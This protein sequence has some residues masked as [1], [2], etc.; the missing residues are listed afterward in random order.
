MGDLKQDSRVGELTTP[1]GKDVLVLVRF[2]GSE[3]LSELFEYRFECLSED[4]DLD[5]DRAI[6]QQCT[7]KLKMYDKEREYNGILV[8]AQWVGIRDAYYLYRLV[9][10]PWLWLLSRTTD[11]RIWLDKKA[12]DIIK[13]V[14]NDRGFT[15]YESKLTE[16]GSCPK[17]EYCVQ[18][19]ETDLNFVSRLMEQH[20]I[21][22]FFK[23]EGGKH[24]LVLADSKSS[25]SPLP[26]LSSIPFVHLAGAD[27]RKEQ[28]IYEWTSERR[29]RTGKFELNDYNYE[30][31]SAQMLSDAKASERYQHSDM[32]F[33]DYPGKYKEKS[34][35]ERYA[36]IQM[37]SEQALDHRRHGNGDAMGI[38]P[39]G[40]TTLKEH[41]QS[42][43]NIEYLV[44]RANHS[45]VAE[46]YRS[47]S[48]GTGSEQIYYGA[49]EFLPSDRPFRAPI[50]TLK[51]LIHGIQTAKVVTKDDNSNEEIDAESIS[52]IYVR[53]HWDRKKKRSCK[54]RVAQVWSGKRWG[55]QFI[56]RVG[57]E[58]VIEFLEGDPDRPLVIGTVYNDD[59]KLPYDIPGN[60]T[61]SGIKSDSTKGGGGYNEW[62]FEDKKG[63]EKIDLHAEKDYQLVIRH[64]ETRT[65]GETF[66]SGT[67][68]EAT[69]KNGD[70]KLDVQNGS[71]HVTISNDQTVD[72]EQ[73]ITVTANISI[74]LKV[75]ASKI[76]LE[77]SGI[78]IEAPT[79]NINSLGAMVINGTPV[80]VN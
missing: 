32:E 59:H 40:L 13:E 9:L 74:E 5:F 70:D 12:P 4:A 39:G 37:Q 42:S 11:C 14:F 79:I 51:P 75:G 24:T 16:E 77:Q 3:G 21:Y 64:A 46:A 80:S 66:G 54:L 35:G 19:R 7:L 47:G 68:R 26:G 23:H 63:S 33:Y 62:N 17:L 31:S 48:Y 2:D 36:K 27:R 69:L 53:F 72:V 1:L 67:S 10:R 55:G 44:V 38:F 50:V 30:K 78:T 8:E 58:A 45:F 49:Y 15:D 60:K 18:Y 25:H 29:L 56:P 61:I 34:D 73:T 43:Q 76:L 57:Q 71:Q 20:G 28:H 6:G 41:A 22:Y 52:E 65:I